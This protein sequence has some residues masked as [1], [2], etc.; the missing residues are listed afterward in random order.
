V[1]TKLAYALEDRRRAHGKAVAVVS[2]DNIPQN[3]RVLSAA[4]RE[5]F[6]SFGSEAEQWLIENVEFVSTSVDRITPRTS[7]SDIEVIKTLTGWKDNSPVITEPFSDWILQGEFPLGRPEWELAGAKFVKDIEPFEKRKLWLLNGAHSTLA[8]SGLNRG[9]D[10]V[11]EAINDDDCFQIVEQF[12]VEAI[13]ALPV[14][15]LNLNEYREALLSRFRNNRIEHKLSQISVDGLTKITLRIVPVALANLAKGTI[16]DGCANSI[17]QWIR[18]VKERSFQDSQSEKL[19]LALSKS[20]SER[21]LI[22]LLNEEFLKYEDFTNR[23]LEL[24]TKQPN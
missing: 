11:F 7:A 2:C 9:L 22:G 4:I 13:G 17:A 16:P 3:G 21:A 8:Y 19:K 14:E 10:S 12:W 18:F 5:I 1:L 6:K 15:L 23:I 24:C 20:E